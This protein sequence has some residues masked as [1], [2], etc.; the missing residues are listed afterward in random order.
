M[1]NRN[2]KYKGSIFFCLAMLF[3]MS[4]NNWLDV[5]PKSQV[6]DRELFSSETGFKEALAG[7]Y[8]AM[9]KEGLYGK[10]LTFGM[11][12][13]LGQE[14]DYQSSTYQDDKDYV[15]ENTV[16]VNRI[17]S[18]W[19][20]MYNAVANANKLLAEI[21]DKQAIFTGVNYEVIKG[22][23]LALRAFLHFDLLRLFGA[24]YAEDPDKV[25]IPYVTEYSALVFPQETV[26]AFLDKVLADLEAA[27]G[28][29]ASDPIFTGK[30]VT[31][32]DDNG[33]LVNR[34]VHLNYYAVKGLM[35]R[36]YLYRKDYTNAARCATEVIESG[37]FE[38]VKQSNLTNAQTADLTFSTEHLFALNVAT[39][40]NTAEKYFS[41]TSGNNV[42]SITE[43]TLL[44]YYET[45]EDYRYLY[46]FE[47]GTGA[48]SS[49]RYLKKFYQLDGDGNT[50]WNESYR[51]KIPLMK[52]SEMYYILAECRQNTGGDVLAPVNE[53]RKHRGIVELT[54]NDLSGFDELLLS[55]FRKEV[56]GEGQLFFY[57][58]R[59]NRAQ[60]KRTDV[61][62]IALKAYK[63]P[64]PKAEYDSPGRVDNR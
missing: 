40:K 16:T 25:A 15:Y 47:N 38:W 19:T 2:E 12:G 10:E 36:V 3:C 23:A 61:D 35:A 31:V 21:D 46:Q 13:V 24:S 52:L 20:N 56:L 11:V 30:S 4:C 8:G 41:N 14:W 59:L 7:V 53:V 58:K 34:Q 64:M 17:D 44:A 26:T 9:T 57:Y 29:L 51:N 62:V 22:E 43:A 63:L 48:N 39:L 55:E 33:Y 27:A 50:P 37:R 60:I 54:E 1:K 6:K 18:I 32:A 49:S 28:Y 42:F 45:A 5:D